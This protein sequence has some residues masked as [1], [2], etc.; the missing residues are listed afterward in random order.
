M[1]DGRI[2]I[3]GSVYG[4]AAEVADRTGAVWTM[5]SAADGTRTREQIVEAVMSTHPD[6]RASA[7]HTALDTFADAGYLEDAAA[8]DPS[9]L[10]AREKE[11]YDRSRRFFR[12]IDLNRRDHS[13]EPQLRLRDSRA[14]VLGVGGTGG[15]A[16]LALVA[17]GVGRVHCVDSDVVE[18]SNLNRQVLYGEAD[19]GRPKAEAAV[20]RLRNLNSDV[21]VTGEVRRIV[22]EADLRELVGDCDVLLLCADQ[23]TEI[24][25]W[26]NRACLDSGTPWVESG[27]HGPIASA[28][29]Y[30]PGRG[31]CFECVWLAEQDRRRRADPEAHHGMLSGRRNAVIAPSA[32]LSGHLAAHLALALLTGVPPIEPGQA[33]GINLVAADH[34]FLITDPRRP[35]CPACGGST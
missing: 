14:V 28:S 15:S 8:S 1:A 12:W 17:S 13:W 7:V 11:R 33:Q 34:H 35:D 22:A 5:L 29:A 3:G 27:Y 10:T 30:T 24:R 19:I 31:P 18:L 2:R 21:Q 4:I 32:G 16:V 20:E 6:E 9:Q 26:T 25:T 23:P